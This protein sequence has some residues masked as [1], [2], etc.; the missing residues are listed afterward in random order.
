LRNKL[1]H[2]HYQSLNLSISWIYIFESF[3]NCF[4][5]FVIDPHLL[6]KQKVEAEFFLQV[7]SK[8]DAEEAT[9]YSINHLES[10]IHHSYSLL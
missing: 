5:S 3:N 1:C 7:L 6:Y 9:S 2:R 4:D 10:R 8:D